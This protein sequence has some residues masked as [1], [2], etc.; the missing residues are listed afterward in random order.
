MGS[1]SDIFGPQ[2]QI[3][4]QKWDSI[5]KEQLVAPKKMR[6]FAET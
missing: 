5:A 1:K 4:F 3:V 6:T 2:Y